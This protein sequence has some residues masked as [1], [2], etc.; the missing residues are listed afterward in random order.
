MIH[1]PSPRALRVV[2]FNDSPTARA[3]IRHVLEADGMVIVAEAA[4]GRDA[5][6]IVAR[7]RADVVVMDVVMPDVNGY[8]ATRAVMDHVPTPIVMVSGVVDP[9]DSEVIFAALAAGALHVAELPP[10]SAVA[11]QRGGT[12]FA[13]IVRTMAGARLRQ[14][15]NEPAPAAERAAATPASHGTPRPPARAQR[16]VSAQRIVHAIGLVTSTGG[17][18]ALVQILR[19]L[20]QAR[21]PPILVVQHLAR[22]FADSF[23]H[24]LEQST[25][26]RVEMAAAGAEPLPGVV[27]VAPE[28]R[29]LGI[30]R[31]RSW[32]LSLVVSNAPA[33]SQFR[34]SGTFLLHSLAALGTHALGVVLTGM[35]RDGAEGAA[36]LR[37]AGGLVAVQDRGTSV[38]HGMPAATLACGGADAVLPLHQVASWLRER[39]GLS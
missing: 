33:V 15:V 28:D 29:H 24:W 34:P 9:K 38:I 35:G 7:S 26:Q 18:Q 21:M 22:G 39:S 12:A 23:A 6:G 17:P 14:Q 2:I 13:A 1:Q 5:A 37:A 25:D 27:Y 32:A 4:T 19:D 8:E 16:S 11:Q 31:A 30:H 10:G 36:A 20:P 3:L